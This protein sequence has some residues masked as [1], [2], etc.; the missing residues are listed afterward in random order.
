MREI[1]FSPALGLYHACDL[2][3]SVHQ[4]WVPHKK[5][6]DSFSDH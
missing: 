4:V 5:L 3:Y 6:L 1:K 2:E